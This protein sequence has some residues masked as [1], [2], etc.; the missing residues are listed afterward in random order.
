[1]EIAWSVEQKFDL[2]KKTCPL[3][4]KIFFSLLNEIYILNIKRD[5]IFYQT[6]RTYVTD[7]FKVCYWNALLKRMVYNRM[8]FYI[9][10]KRF[11][12]FC[13]HI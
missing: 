4:Q 3:T 9:S 6:V 12:I 8:S 7:L 13:I 2:K 1:M 10:P 5:F 11:Y